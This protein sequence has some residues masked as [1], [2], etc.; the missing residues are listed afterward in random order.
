MFLLWLMNL[1]VMASAFLLTYKVFRFADFI[2]SLITWFILYFT[3]I[4]STELF[5][6]IIGRLYLKNVILVNAVIFLVI[7]ILT[8]NKESSFSSLGVRQSLIAAAHN[9]IILLGASLLLGFGLVKIF[10]NLINPPFG[11]DCLSYHFSFPVEW[12]KRGDLRI[13]ATI[14]DD[15]SP[16]YYPINGSLL[17]L[18]FMLPLQNVFI[19]DLAQVP[20]FILAF[21]AIYNACQKLSLNKELSFYAASLFLITPNVFKQLEIAYVDLMLTALFLSGINFLLSL[22]KNFSLRNLILFSVSFGLFLGTKTSAAVYGIFLLFFFVIALLKNFRKPKPKKIAVFILLFILIATAL[23]GFTYI[24]NFLLTGNALYP[25]QIKI[26]GKVLFKGVM[27]FATYREKWTIKDFNLEKLLFHE[28]MGLQFLILVIPAIFLSLPILFIKRKDQVNFISLYI[29]SLPIWLYLAFWFFMPQ[30]WVR[31]LYPF[32]GCGF[33]VAMCT[34]DMLNFPLKVTRVIVA[35]CFLASIAELSGHLELAS[36]IILSILIFIL[37]PFILQRLKFNPGIS[38]ATLF[39]IFIALY[40]LNL[41]YDKYEFKRYL[42]TPFP[43]E[44]KEAWVWLDKNTQQAKIAYTGS[45]DT[46]P[47]YGANFKNE[48]VYIS[49]N[50]THPAKIHYFP[51]AKYIWTGD[52]ITLHQNL[53]KAGNYR[54]NPDYLVWLKNLKSEGT[55]CLLVYAFHQVKEPT[56]PIEDAWAASHSKIFNLV[57]TNPRV[58]IYRIIK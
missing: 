10:I 9:K 21:L 50:A 7:F 24:R 20:F 32:L 28:G 23:G 41:N 39:L 5:L 36:S 31:Y 49:V 4:I 2:D 37:L 38:G 34:L 58:H 52:F 46:L 56:F 1:I 45:P 18:W 11:W 19:A 3:Q 57:F 54:Q 29:L 15:P 27:P 26:G 30:L 16:P 8:R 25:A 22:Y 13:M 53:E 55:D 33:M 14:A 40:F 35:I 17:F 48:I 47:L 6:G 43:Q 44:E 51:D 42:R 12:L